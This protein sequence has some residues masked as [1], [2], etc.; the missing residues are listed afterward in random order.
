LRR[1]DL[2]GART[3][4]LAKAFFR[5]LVEEACSQPGC[6]SARLANVF[7]IRKLNGHFLREHAA[8]RIL[9]AAADVLLDSVDAFNDRLT[10]GTVDLEHLAL[11]AAIVAGDYFNRVTSAN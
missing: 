1:S 2:A 11:L 4:F 10:R 6:G 3:A 5:A 9:L 8:L 7:H